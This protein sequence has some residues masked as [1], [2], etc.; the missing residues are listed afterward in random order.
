MDLA[1]DHDVGA[2]LALA[3]TEM[4]AKV[5]AGL[6][7]VGLDVGL[8][9]GQPMVAAPAE[10]TAAHAKGNVYCGR[11]VL[12]VVHSTDP[13]MTL[14]S[15]YLTHFKESIYEAHEICKLIGLVM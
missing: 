13:G 8:D 3:L 1:I 7:P 12:S 11:I 15:I 6:K 9:Q 2:C 10:A 14:V 4:A 5:D